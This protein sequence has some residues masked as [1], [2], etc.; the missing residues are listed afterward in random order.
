MAD[1]NNSDNEASASD[2]AQEPPTEP[3]T[4]AVDEAPAKVESPPQAPSR[5]PHRLRGGLILGASLT[6]CFLMMASSSQIPRGPLWGFLVML[7]GAFGLL[8]FLGLLTMSAP[9]AIPVVATGLGAKDGEFKF[10]A[11]LYTVPAALIIA[12]FG[13]YM[14]GFDLLPAV[15]LA[16]LLTLAPSALRRP[17]LAVFVIIGLIYLPLAGTFSLWDPWETHYGEVAREMLA[18]DDWISLWWAQENWFWSK[19]ILIFWSDAFAMGAL[20]IDY[21]PDSQLKHAEW[22][23]RLPVIAMAMTALIAVYNAVGRNFGK[24][25]GL[26][27][28]LVL[29]TMPHFFFLA[30]QAITD[31][32]FVSNMTTAISLL[33]LALTV[34]PEREV[35]TYQVGKL[36]LSG[37]HAVITLIFMV[38]GPQALYLASRNVSFTDGFQFA[39]HGDRFMYGSAGNNGIPGNSPVRDVVPYVSDVPLVGA[40]VLLGIALVVVAGLAWWLRGRKA[41][42]VTLGSG[43]GALAVVVGL[44]RARRASASSST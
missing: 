5:G 35:R 7:G 20:G 24:R 40:L 36:V 8:D 31:M 32:P 34:D 39:W 17:G 3:P 27:S 33:I 25:A 28:A 1:Q 4:D 21:L 16:A 15:I 44:V 9:N 26:L 19:P 2:E 13:G 37:R 22:A 41:G 11:P 23:L 18:R 10:F 43:V 12:V 29:G 6:A 14:L 42:L 30:H 38:V